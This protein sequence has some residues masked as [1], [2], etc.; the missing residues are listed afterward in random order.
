M[1]LDG[2]QGEGLGENVGRLEGSSEVLVAKPLGL[3]TLPHVVVDHQKVFYLLTLHRVL[4]HS[5]GSSR[6]TIDSDV[7]RICKLKK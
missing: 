5:N 1:S 7:N 2:D 4:Y 3:V 6:V